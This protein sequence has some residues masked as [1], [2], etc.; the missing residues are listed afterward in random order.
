MFFPC[1]IFLLKSSSCTCSGAG[2]FACI[3]IFSLSLCSFFGFFSALFLLLFSLF[4]FMQV[5]CIIRNI[6]RDWA[7]EVIFCNCRL[8][9]NVLEIELLFS[10]TGLIF[11]FLPFILFRVRSNVM[12]AINQFLRNLIVFFLTGAGKLTATIPLFIICCNM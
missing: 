6:V 9:Y 4:P 2:P 11:I 1:L 8:F 5:R 7:Q 10:C 12:S 3:C